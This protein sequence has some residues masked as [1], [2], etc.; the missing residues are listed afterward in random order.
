MA[1]GTVDGLFA[2]HQVPTLPL[3]AVPQ[4]LQQ[5][6]RVLRPGGV[7]W[8]IVPDLEALAPHVATGALDTPLFAGP[9]GPVTGAQLL[10]G[11]SAGAP[12]PGVPATAHT[13]PAFH[14]GYSGP[15]L[16]RLLQQAGFE[17]IR[18]QRD[19]GRFELLATA[20]RPLAVQPPQP[21][22]GTAQAWFERGRQLQAA[23]QWSAA[24][25]AYRQAL[26]LD[27]TLWPA[28]YEWGVT[29]F[30]QGRLAEAIDHVQ[31]AIAQEGRYARAH[32]ALGSFLGM[33]GRPR[34]AAA[35]LQRAAELDPDVAENH[36]N[37]GKAWQELN[38]LTAAEDAY[39]QALKLDP[40]FTLAQLN[41]GSV[42]NEH[43]LMREGLAL[44][45]AAAPQLDDP[46]LGSN[47]PMLLNFSDSA[48][49]AEVYAAHAAYDQRHAQ[50]LMPRPRP[51]ARNRQP[52][53]R[54][55]VGYLSRDFRTHSLG[56]FLL[57]ILRHHHRQQFE[58]VAYCDNTHQDEATA[59]YRALS[60]H[61]LETHTLDDAA[62]AQ[63]I[64]E[65][66]VDIL[67]DLGGH[68]N[69]NR[70]LVMARQPAPI[71]VTYLG[72]PATTGLSAIDWRI[73]D[74]WIDPP[75]APGAA[76]ASPSSSEQP[77]RLQHG[78]FCYAPRA[79]SP[80]VGPCPF[81]H[82]GHITLGALHQG[83]KLTPQVIAV[84]A[85]VLAGLPTARLCLQNAALHEA[86]AQDR[87]RAAFAQHGVAPE[88][89]Q[90]KPF[91]KAPHYLASYHGID[92][93]L[94]SFPYNGG[95]TTCE[96]LWMGVPVVSWCGTR[97]VSRL[98]ASI[99]HNLQ[100]GDLVATSAPAYVQTVLTL[101]AAP[102]RLRALRSGLRQRMA[103][104][105]MMDHAGFTA[106]LESALRGIW[107]QHC[108]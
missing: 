74:R 58:V 33:V 81:E 79:D 17:A 80:D 47:L 68:T 82:N 36:Y 1:D 63:R 91:A 13:A 32:A 66:G 12:T 90:F 38:A 22:P 35:S 31:Q 70:L 103:A 71:Q 43:G 51:P 9:L 45:R 27:H 19:P 72:Y 61:W 8:L 76:P 20:R 102:E 96:A 57:P 37:L 67:F 53:R 101:A 69:R 15:S 93:A 56:Y 94:D 5:C 65:D 85:Q 86:R 97:H 92:I 39:R 7:V 26:A 10:W 54:L 28:R 84:W 106:E 25:A 98:G 42:L 55:R 18:L 50:P 46:A 75:P 83:S 23:R 16:Q 14:S 62:L 64:A 49:D 2:A 95:T 89:L 24:E 77:L 73:S 105:P 6:L 87:L 4:T 100:L 60:D 108:G 11:G 107:V 41:L 21:A 48:S 59:Q 3:H 104:S 78:Y 40:R 30:S 44:Y 34:D 88:R 99:L 29:C 52:Q